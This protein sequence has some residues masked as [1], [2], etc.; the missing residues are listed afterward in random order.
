[1][2]HATLEQWAWLFILVCRNRSRLMHPLILVNYFAPA[3]TSLLSKA[4]SLKNSLFNYRPRLMTRARADE[5]KSICK[6]KRRFSFP[7][8]RRVFWRVPLTR[9]QK[10]ERVRQKQL[11][12][13]NQQRDKRGGGA[14]VAARAHPKINRSRLVRS[15]AP[16]HA[17]R[18][19]FVLP[20]R[21]HTCTGIWFAYQSARGQMRG[22]N[23]RTK[24]EWKMR[25][26]V[27]NRGRGKWATLNASFQILQLGC[28]S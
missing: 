9:R 15:F 3:E 1:M 17:E 18:V 24:R 12:A 14:A 7:P 16:F 8:Q 22:E 10:P 28:S 13:A 25:T 11:S 26:F 19:R 27:P 20:Q 4:F 2:I 6:G 5:E 21:T 23:A